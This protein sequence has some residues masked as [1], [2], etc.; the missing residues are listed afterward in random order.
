MSARGGHTQAVASASSDV[1]GASDARAEGFNDLGPVALPRIGKEE[2]SARHVRGTVKLFAGQ[3]HIRT[4]R[5]HS[6]ADAAWVLA[7]CVIRRFR[8]P[9]ESVAAS[10]VRSFR[11]LQTSPP[12]RM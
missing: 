11:L 9:V 6:I 12:L 8:Q 1:A 10:G 3:G 5:S 2:C 4:Y 7:N